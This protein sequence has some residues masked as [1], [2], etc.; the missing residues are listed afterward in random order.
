MKLGI[1]VPYFENRQL[2]RK[3]L[4]SIVKQDSSDWKLLIIDDSGGKEPVDLTELKSLSQDFELVSNHSTLGIGECWNVGLKCMFDR[5]KPEIL[6]VVHADDEL[7]KDYVSKVISA[8][9]DFPHAFA[10]YTGVKII[11]EASNEKFSFPDYI[12]TLISPRSGSQ[13][14][15]L[16]GDL[17]LSRL[18]AGDFIFCPTLS[19]KTEQVDLP[20]FDSKWQMV[21]DLD[22]LSRA[23]ISNKEIVGI[24]A[25]IYR[26]RRHD[27]N[28]T[29]QLNRTMARFHEEIDF[30]LDL[31]MKCRATGFSRSANAA[32][33]MT[34]IKLHLVF[35]ILTSVFRGQISRTRALYRILRIAL[36][37]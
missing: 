34:I 36:R 17:G 15:V 28:L 14:T 1:V 19:F 29:A 16:K 37:G 13:H 20:L 3:L 5:F 25:K 11:D 30:Y 7:E 4:H 21:V 27:H 33:Q 26:Y 2:L 18:L 10:I 31:S 32:S 24:P 9:E 8:H 35:Q 22:L 23:L 6:S 12:K